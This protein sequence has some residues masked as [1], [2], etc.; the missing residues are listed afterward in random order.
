MRSLHSEVHSA[1]EFSP[2]GEWKEH[3]V[4]IILWKSIASA[5]GFPPRLLAPPPTPMSPSILFSFPARL[6]DWGWEAF[7]LEDSLDFLR[8]IPPLFLIF[9]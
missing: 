5:D 3:C 9:I 6:I 4:A 8:F 2:R 7:R 1:A